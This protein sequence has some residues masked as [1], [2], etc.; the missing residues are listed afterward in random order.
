VVS[1]VRS[2]GH[3]RHRSLENQI[4]KALDRWMPVELLMMMMMMAADGDRAVGVMKDVVTDTAEYRSSD[5]AETASTHHYHRCMFHRR[6]LD[7]RLAGTCSESDYNSSAN[8]YN[9]SHYT[10]QLCIAKADG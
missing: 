1:D 5:E 4:I 2:I 9:P 3:L 8:L 10:I 7:D 6:Q